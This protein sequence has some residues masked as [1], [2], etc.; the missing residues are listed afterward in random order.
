VT[1]Y[2]TSHRRGHFT[3]CGKRTWY[4]RTRWTRDR[5]A[6]TCPECKRIL[7]EKEDEQG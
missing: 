5:Y 7:R 2:A 6:V 3:L 1:H 4:R